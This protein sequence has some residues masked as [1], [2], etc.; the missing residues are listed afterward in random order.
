MDRKTLTGLLLIV[1][2]FPLDA[3]AS[4]FQYQGNTT[5]QRTQLQSGP[6]PIAQFVFDGNIADAL[7][8]S[9]ME[10]VGGTVSFERGLEGLALSLGNDDRSAFLSLN[11]DDLPFDGNQDF[12]VQFWMRT[13]VD[14]GKRFVVLSHKDFVDNSLAS[15][16]E[17][18]WAFY[19]SGGTWAWNMGSGDR[20]I[21]YERDNGTHM[22]V[23]DGRWHQLTMTYERAGSAVRLFYDGD[24]K[25]TYNVRDSD[26]FDFGNTDP[27][28]VG[29]AVTGER[30]RPE[31]LPAIEAG[32]QQ[33]Q[34]LV[35]AFNGFGLA[36]LESDD[37]VHLIVDPKRLFDQRVSQRIEQLGADS[38]AFREAMASVDWEPISALE[39]AL[40]TNPYT[41]HQV[42]NF[43]DV[44]PLMRIYALDDGQVIIKQ[45]AAETYADMERLHPPE[46][47]MDNL[48]IWDRVLSSEEVLASY[49]EH[50]VP[51]VGDPEAE[52]TSLT[53]GCWNIWHG[54]K[55]FTVDEHGWDSRVAIAEILKGENADV[56]MMQETYSSGDFIAAELG[57][58]FATT[59][60][61]DYLNQGSNISVLSRYPIKE[62]YVQDDSPFMNVA[63]KVAI[64]NTQDMYVM[65]NW[66]GMQQFSAVFDFHQDR[67]RQSDIIPTLFAGD[68]NAVPHT[69]S[70]GSPASLALLGAGF[71]DAFR[72]L[73]PDVAAHPGHSHRSGSRIDQLYYKGAGLHNTSTRVISTW[74]TGFPSDHY[75]IVSTFDLDY[76]TPEGGR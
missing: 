9:A 15:Q 22:P 71:T 18:G 24:N 3:E 11:S 60:D 37:F 58:Y 6:G 64:S 35:D 72:S 62:V 29:W 2:G 40:M 54:G 12:S 14:V 34:D 39:R 16:K 75:L 13:V 53:A 66:Y 7:G 19:V 26:G 44:A 61:W 57:Y 67:F 65:S 43:M 50:F 45:S 47:D 48:S 55:H 8:T 1:A 17:A 21:T 30:T 36:E 20:R 70:G 4:P 76:A 25:V 23:N 46:F 49:S 52:L 59:V 10:T 68:F 41:V 27:L 33:L 32:A 28:A 56:V 42:L 51:A 31:V 69:D 63:A 74:P 5:H 38:L 73:Y